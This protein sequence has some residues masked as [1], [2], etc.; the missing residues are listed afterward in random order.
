MAHRKFRDREGRW[1]EVRLRSRSEWDLEPA[2]DNPAR[3][4][5]VASPGYEK[6]PWELSEEELQRLLDGSRE[7]TARPRKSPFQD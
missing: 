3:A 2:G 6:D 5:S 1:W 4:R 7:P